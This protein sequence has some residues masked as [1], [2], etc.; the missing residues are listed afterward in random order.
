MK[1]LREVLTVEEELLD[2]YPSVMLTDVA[3]DNYYKVCETSRPELWY[4]SM[5]KE[6]DGI[7]NNGTLE[8]P[9]ELPPGRRALRPHW[10]YKIKRGIPPTEPEVIYKSRLTINGST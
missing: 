2:K 5:Q 8:G 4:A 1:N 9:V 10:V 7:V 3:P 6:I